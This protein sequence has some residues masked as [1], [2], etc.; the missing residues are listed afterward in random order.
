MEQREERRQD[1]NAHEAIDARNE[2]LLLPVHDLVQQFLLF[3]REVVP[4]N[5]EQDVHHPVHLCDYHVPHLVLVGDQHLVYYLGRGKR[6]ETEAESH[7]AKR[8]TVPRQR[9]RQTEREMNVRP[10]L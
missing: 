10:A 2:R 7:K 4:A 9:D 1:H 8:R 3:R 5:V 6:A